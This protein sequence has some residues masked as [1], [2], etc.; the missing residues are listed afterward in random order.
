MSICLAARSARPSFAGGRQAA[1]VDSLTLRHQHLLQRQKSHALLRDA[2]RTWLINERLEIQCF[3]HECL[4]VRNL[5]VG[6]SRTQAICQSTN[7]LVNTWL[8]GV[9]PEQEK[10]K[11]HY[12][13]NC[14]A[15]GCIIS[16]NRLQSQDPI[17]QL[18]C[19]IG[20]L[21]LV[22]DSSKMAVVARRLCSR[23]IIFNLR[24][25]AR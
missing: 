5:K 1:A 8:R 14:H 24:W 6:T 13:H 11:A 23:P 10:A 15:T 17:F 3:V 4:N 12:K 19:K 22:H 20:E 7:L 21:C 25:P 18:R 16:C 2:S 9:K